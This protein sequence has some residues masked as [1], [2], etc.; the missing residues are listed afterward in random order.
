MTAQARRLIGG[1]LLIF[2]LGLQGSTTAAHRAQS[3]PAALPSGFTISVFA[4][5]VPKARFL[6]YSPQGDLYVGQL[7]GTSGSITI[8]PDRNHDGQADRAVVIAT[9]LLSPNNVTFRPSGFGT[10]FAAGAYDRVKVYTDTRGDL[11]F[12][13]STVLIDNLPA[14][15]ARRHKTKTVAYGPD[16]MLYVAQ[17]SI[18]DDQA[19]V[20][21]TAGLWRYNAD[22][23]G[24]QKIAAGLRN[25]EGYAWDAVG[26]GL[27]G[28]DNGSD[29][30]GAN[31]PHD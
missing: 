19:N 16:G 6:A 7:Q 26:G 10:V 15:A 23:S 1:G 3:V 20:D 29:N 17:G 13:E 4:E 21:P 28:A 22:G 25:T 5:N 18:A 2:L 14:E 31:L 12:A 11:S 24:K 27:W 8:L 30:L 9:E